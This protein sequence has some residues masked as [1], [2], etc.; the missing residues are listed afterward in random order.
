[1]ERSSAESGLING[2]SDERVLAAVRE[3]W[4][5]DTLRPMQAEAVRASLDNRDS[6][7]VMPTGGGKSLCYQVPPLLTGKLTVVVSPLIALMQDQVSGLTIAGYPAAALNSHVSPDEAAKVRAAARDGSL[8]LLF[9]APERLLLDGTVSWL[10][11]LGDR[12]GSV[13][14]DE[15]HCISQWGHDFRP[16]YRRLA[17]LRDHLPGLAI[18]AY[19]ATA[20]PRVR[21][22]VVRQLRL[23]DPLVLV[24]RFDRPNLTYRVIPRTRMVEQVAQVLARH[25]GRAAIVYCISRKETESLAAALCAKGLDARAY[26]AGMT[27][28]QRTRTSDDFK[29]ERLNIVCATVAF[30]MGIDRGD[31]RCV[32]HAAIPKSVEHYQQETG[33]AGRDGLPSECVLLHSAADFER[34]RS[35]MERSAA[36]T[37]AT[38]ESLQAQLEL[39]RHLKGVVSTGRCRHR[40]LTEYFGQ[41]YEVPSGNDP[42]KG[43]GACDVCLGELDEIADAQVVAQK[44]ISCVYRV[45]QSFGAGH[46]ADVLR[47]SATKKLLDKGHDRLSTFALL[48][49]LSRETIV[50]CVHQLVDAGALA[51][52]PGE[53]PVITMTAASKEFLS[54]A[55]RAKLL[56]ARREPEAEPTRSRSRARFD[57]SGTG[58]RGGAE[59]EA[60]AL[61][62]DEEALFDSLRVLRRTIAEELGVPPFVVFA[63]TTL[64][65]LSRV[66]PGTIETL[67]TVKGIGRKKLEQFGERFLGHVT[68]WCRDHGLGLDA[69]AGSRRV[70]LG[71]Q[72]FEA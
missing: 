34:W 38:P 63:D 41:K 57:S 35:L 54:G 66:R 55:R 48:R 53:Y 56:E 28:Q 65:E 8:K 70:R 7:I 3:T 31:V 29:S 61:T 16:E 37:G 44:I 42:E 27:P 43:C 58:L 40:G 23:R 17:E 59:A 47:G 13:A 36:E 5:F 24:G 12:V 69:A 25:E 30:G 49:D 6:L 20:T 10:R 52:A 11:G 62:K 2:V 4:G 14:V 19:T 46:V 71:E 21:E 15:A 22:D 72:V 64:E 39:L 45:G 67:A 32:V 33:R 51:V 50:S 9:I 26:H 18:H 60:P 1:M 68:D